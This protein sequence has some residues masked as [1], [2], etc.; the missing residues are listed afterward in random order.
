MVLTLNV[1]YHW[2]YSLKKKMYFSLH[3]EW[4]KQARVHDDV[5]LWS[6]PQ[7]LVSKRSCFQLW[8]A[9]EWYNRLVYRWTVLNCL[10]MNIA[11]TLLDRS[12]HTVQSWWILLV[13]ILGIWVWQ[14]SENYLGKLE[15]CNSSITTCMLNR[16]ITILSLYLSSCILTSQPTHQHT[17]DITTPCSIINQLYINHV[18][19]AARPYTDFCR[20]Q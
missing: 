15:T 10:A 14:D 18:P 11:R 2:I 12:K 20:L 1:S 17:S 19:T 4:H 5:L 9:R 3:G 6:Y 13:W 16:I 8:K 7:F